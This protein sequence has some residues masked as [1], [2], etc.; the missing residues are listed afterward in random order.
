[1]DN[2]LLELLWNKYWVM[3]LSQSPLMSVSQF[4]HDCIFLLILMYYLES[5]IHYLTDHRFDR[6]AIKDRKQ[7]IITS[8]TG[9]TCA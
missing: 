2:A 4:S 6:K 8:I 5:S 7:P 3:T 9:R 1:M